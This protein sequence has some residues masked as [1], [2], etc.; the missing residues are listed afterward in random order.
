MER[1]LHIH[2]HRDIQGAVTIQ[3]L[4]V[5]S[6][7]IAPRYRYFQVKHVALHDGFGGSLAEP[8]EVRFR[9]SIRI[10]LDRLRYSVHCHV[11]DLL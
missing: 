10:A 9:S 11:D 8:A 4:A 1:T 7:V 3:R 5:V 6:A 2:D